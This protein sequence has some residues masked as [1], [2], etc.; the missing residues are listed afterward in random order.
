MEENLES[1][2]N[3]Y[4]K[5]LGYSGEDRAC[6]YLLKNGYSVVA[7]NF[8]VR[9]GE[10]DIVAE[11]GETLVI[12]EVKTLPHGDSETLKKVLNA[13][14]I[15]TLV[16]TTKHFL[17]KHRQYNNSYIRFDVLALDLPGFPPVFHIENAFT[18]I[19]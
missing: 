11:K 3:L 19:L 15:K 7:R 2:K 4:K 17:L 6:E 1:V 10:L 12:F 8:T 16:R 14:K 13:Q 5:K 18:E 9:G